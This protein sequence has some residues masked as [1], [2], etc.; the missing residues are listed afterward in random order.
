MEN[1]SEAYSK[2]AIS[3]NELIEE[4]QGLLADLLTTLNLFSSRFSSNRN[5]ENAIKYINNFYSELFT[6]MDREHDIYDKIMCY[7]ASFEEPAML[8]DEEILNM[9][10]EIFDKIENAILH[11][12]LF[13]SEINNHFRDVLDSGILT[14]SNYLYSNYISILDEN[15]KEKILS[16]IPGDN[17][18]DLY[19]DVL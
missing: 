7:I 10:D 11:R 9:L 8:D 13:Y 14:N 19:R 3:R 6:D 4:K 2:A 12:L 1:A 5:L 15:T 18:Y 17:D 16:L